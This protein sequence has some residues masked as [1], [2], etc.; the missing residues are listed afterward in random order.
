MNA[1]TLALL[2]CIY[3]HNLFTLVHILRRRKFIHTIRQPA[4][5][6]SWMIMIINGFISSILINTDMREMQ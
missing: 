1:Q 2:V 5:M 6:S 4:A 3:Q